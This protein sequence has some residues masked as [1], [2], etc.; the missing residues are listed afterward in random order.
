MPET[1]LTTKLFIPPS[2]PNAIHRAQLLDRLSAGLHRKLTLISAPAGFGKTTLVSEWIASEGHP[3]AWLSLDALDSDPTRFLTYLIAAVQTVAPEVGTELRAALT[4]PQP[5]AIESVLPVLINDLA[6]VPSHLIVVLDDYHLIESSEIDNALAFLIGHLPPQI[7]VFVTTREDPQLPLHGLRANGQLNELRSGDLRFTTT[8]AAEFLNQ[9]IGLELS[10]QDVAALD[11]R[12]EGWIAGLQMAGLSLQGSDNPTSFISSFSGSHRFVLDYLLEEVW[13]RQPE[14]VHHF[15]RCTSILNRVCGSLCDAVVRDP[16][17]SGQHMLEYLERSNLFLGP[18]DN[19]RHWYRYHHLFGEM[20][21]Q[22]LHHSVAES[23]EDIADLHL[24][25]SLWFEEN[26][27][28][29]EAF[30]HAIAAND[31]ER[32][33]R[34]IA[35]SGVP[36]YVRGGVTPVLNWLESLPAA[37][38]DARPRLWVEFATALGVIGRFT[39]VE[40]I[41]Q[42]AERALQNHPPSESKH[43]LLSRIADLRGLASLLAFDPAVVETIITQTRSRLEQMHNVTHPGRAAGYWKLGLA[44]QV[45]GNRVKARLAQTEAIASSEATGNNHINVLATT[46]LGNMQE[47]DGQLHLAAT[48][49]QRVL[50]MVGQ[51]P[52]PVACEAHVGL[53]RIHCEWNEL[54][55]AEEHGKRSVHLARQLEI[56]SFVSS[57]VFLAQLSLARSDIS[58]ATSILDRTE[59]DVHELN[60]PF[61]LPQIAAAQASTLLRSGAIEA[62]EQLAGLYDLPLVQARVHLDR[63]EPARALATLDS[64]RQ[65]PESEDSALE[66]LKVLILKA[67][68]HQA[69]GDQQSAMHHLSEALALGEVEGFVRVFIDEGLPMKALLSVANKAGIRPGYTRKL[70]DAYTNGVHVPGSY[71]EMQQIG[72]SP[73]LIEPL[74]RRE[75]EIL[76]LVAEGLSNKEISERLFLS[77]ATVKGHNLVIF[78]KLQVQRRTEAVARA[79]DLGLI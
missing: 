17:I 46:C 55:L 15:L 45:Q 9:T 21:Q 44:Y 65:H 79:R 25:A 53:A 36:L 70:L 3:A 10:P 52:G 40:A 29:L 75:V 13:K 78:R 2:R 61:R 28:E 39:R 76:Q 47:L 14:S 6:N 60:F 23:G 37:T 57:E 27:L 58:S 49:Y 71:L 68:A 22:R 64:R 20:L 56:A 24:R 26:H 4:S 59:R 62:A 11:S 66:Q 48:T 74:S 43:V 8:E 7:H 31:V 54:D 51:P 30:Q 72:T 32:A 63:A 5:P 38:L 42:S 1:I 50:Q 18:L 77:L 16:S 12:T 19:E 35:G 73:S 69:T 41:L 34:L 33:E 67:I